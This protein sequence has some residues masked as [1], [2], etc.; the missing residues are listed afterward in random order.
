MLHPNEFQI[1]DA[2][3]EA[4]RRSH[5]DIASIARAT[6]CKESSI[7][8]VKEHLFLNTHRLDRYV[9]QGLPAVQARFDSDPRIAAAW[10][11]LESGTFDERDLVFLKHEAAE[12]WYMRNVDRSYDAAH[13]AAQ[14]RFPAPRW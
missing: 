13:N 6:K 11:R 1:A 4:I 12:A 10:R 3:Y 14:K 9:N 8:K 2:D 7:R 5:S